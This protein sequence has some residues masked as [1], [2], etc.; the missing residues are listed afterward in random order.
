M[1]K[2]RRII[3]SLLATA[4]AFVVHAQTTPI[5][6]EDPE[7]KRICVENWDTNGDGELS[8][9]EAAAVTDIGQ[10]FGMKWGDLSYPTIQHFNEFKFFTGVKKIPDNAFMWCV[11]L[12]SIALPQNLTSIGSSAFRSCTNLEKIDLP[13]G[14]ISIGSEA[15]S[16]CKVLDVVTLPPNLSDIGGLAFANCYKFESITIPASVK[17]IGIAPFGY[18]ENF[19]EIRVAGD[20]VTYESPEGSNAIVE[21]AT[22]TLVVGCKST[23]IPDDVLRI[24]YAAFK[25]VTNIQHI[26]L[27]KGLKYISSYAFEDCHSLMDIVLPEHLDSIMIGAFFRCHSLQSIYIPASVKFISGGLF[28]ETE[29]LKSIEVSKDNKYYDSR[30]QC[31][32]IIRTADNT[33]NNGCEATIIPSSVVAIGN[34]AFSNHKYFRDIDIPKQVTI[35]EGWAYDN[36]SN[37][38]KIVLHSKIK[39]IDT[40]AFRYMPSLDSVVNYMKVPLPIESEVFYGKNPSAT[41]FVPYGTKSLYEQAEGWKDF[42]NI[43]EMDPGPE[44][45]ELVEYFY[46]TDPGHGKGTIINNVKEGDNTLQLSTNGLQPGP[47]LLF[48]RSQSSSGAWSTTQAHAFYLGSKRGEQVTRLE[49]FFDQDPGYGK[50]KLISNVGIGE[51]KLQ[52]STEGLPTGAHLLFVRSLDDQGHWSSLLAHPFM[53]CNSEGF[54][55]L[56]YFIDDNDPG[57]GNATQ[58]EMPVDGMLTFSIPTDELTAGEHTIYV[59]GINAD[60]IWSQIQQANFMVTQ[61]ELA[62]CA[63]VTYT[64]N[65][66]YATLSTTTDE[67]KIYYTLDGSDPT[68]NSS[69]YTGTIDVGGLT[70]LKAVATKDGMNP[71]D[72]LTYNVPCYYEG[73]TAQVGV[74]GAMSL[75]FGWCDAQQIEQIIITGHLNDDDFATLRSLNALR[76]ANLKQADMVNGS[77]PDNAFAGMGIISIELP[78]AVESVGNSLFANCMQL[79]AIG[80]NA[81]TAIANQAL[82]DIN[83]P[84]LLLYADSEGLVQ[85][86]GVTNVVVGST[87][88]TIRLSDSEGNANFYAMRPFTAQDISYTHRYTMKSG[89]DNCSGWET[90]AL[91]FDVQ[92]ITHENQGVLTPFASGTGSYNERPFWLCELAS[93]GWQETAQV[94]A[95]TPYLIAMPNNEAYSEQYLLAGNVTFASTQVQVPV[96]E[97]HPAIS[98]QTQFVPTTIAIEAAESVFALNLS[99]YDQY[100]EG[101]VFVAG[102]RQVRPFE[103]YRTTQSGARYMPISDDMMSGITH[104]QFNRI[105][106]ADIYDLQG[107]KVRRAGDS[108]SRLR[109]GIYIQ[110]GRKIYVK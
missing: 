72:T 88:N 43:V 63:D 91:P 5:P 106:N 53:V 13:D 86:A 68:E 99:S 24:G 96:S 84:N 48:M 25:G 49:Y 20:N 37:V 16:G 7:V 105:D 10:V 28:G 57:V 21:K 97:A 30:E 83:N 22:K 110:N 76:H 34:A 92:T 89:Y 35:I 75:C 59:R 52:L 102:L 100:S 98:G 18:N 56:E 69:V 82:A 41:L 1:M 104:I 9:D 19:G 81:N 62:P 64:Y 108:N 39:K 33:L 26:P 60:G 58:L 8:Y 15:F 94:K 107:R 31:N 4:T 45:L 101:S 95:N 50:G 103:A 2:T 77:L 32:A 6:F 14:I 78:T 44:E 27:P 80:W 29:S 40:A 61:P 11:I 12:Q 74:A 87:A 54:A 85:S 66:R 71:S 90:I 65:G 38:Q 47:H 70:T 93:T 51:Q 36:C 67:A 17:S 73:T 23:Q 3:M 42:A 79:A 109:P 55:A 46:D